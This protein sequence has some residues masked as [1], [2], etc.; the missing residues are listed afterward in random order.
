M[1]IVIFEQIIVAIFML[2]M[3][4]NKCEF[5]LNIR[6]DG[7]IVAITLRGDQGKFTELRNEDYPC[8]NIGGP[9]ANIH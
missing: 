3:I 7:S 5:K 8:M 1:A 6:R 2:T 9:S 4:Q